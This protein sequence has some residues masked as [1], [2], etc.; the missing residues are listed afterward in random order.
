M[1]HQA[2]LEEIGIPDV[3]L[4]T[5]YMDELNED[6]GTILGNAKAQ[7]SYAAIG[8]K[9]VCKLNEKD[10]NKY[11]RSRGIIGYSDVVYHEDQNGQLDY[12]YFLIDNF[13]CNILDDSLV[14]V[15][16][17]NVNGFETNLVLTLKAAEME[18]SSQKT[19]FCV[20]SAQ[21]GEVETD[22]LVEELFDI[23]NSNVESDDVVG[24]TKIEDKTYFYFDLEP[25]TDKIK[26]FD[27]SI[28]ETKV[29]LKANGEN[30]T[31]EGYLSIE[32]AD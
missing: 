9:K 30:L 12:A 18:A 10:I 20:E 32:I 31:S 14:F 26:E 11:L 22:A 6:A 15:I 28:D 17:L 24:F 7:V 2:L 1:N 23:L 21:F 25:V 16:G 27:D 5:S 19:Y 4:Y 8:S 29:S 3:T 13:Y